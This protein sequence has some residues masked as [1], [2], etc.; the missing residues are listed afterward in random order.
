LRPARTWFIVSAV[1]GLDRALAAASRQDGVIAAWQCRRLGLDPAEVKRLCRSGRWL[2][3]YRGTY[4]VEADVAG[5]PSRRASIRAALL[6]AGPHAVAVRETAAVVHGIGGLPAEGGQVHVS[7]PAR[8]ARPQRVIDRN[9]V[10]H[11]LA[12]EPGQISTVRGIAVTTPL[13]TVADLILGLDRYAAVSVLDSALN[14]GLVT[15]DGLLTLPELIAGRRGAGRARDWIAEADA[16]AESPL[17]TRV[18]LRC[19][20]GRVPPDALQHP[21]H[22]PRGELL[23]IGDLAW[24]G[25]RVLGEADGAAV[26]DQPEA[27]F[28]DRWRQNALANAGWLIIRFTWQDTLRPGYIVEVVRNALARPAA[29]GAP[30]DHEVGYAQR[31][32]PGT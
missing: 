13:R 22:G 27:V 3:L 32:A 30:L 20:D 4:L 16:R 1:D 8:H 12:I 25:A 6:S 26:H 5:G 28:R 18:R 14:R 21:V 7:L 15:G 11:Q 29:A 24:L 2:R 10:L 23:G 17:E 31:R 19:V 9:L